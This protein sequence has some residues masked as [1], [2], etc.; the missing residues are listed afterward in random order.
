MNATIY[1]KRHENGGLDFYL[2]NNGRQYYLYTT[3][4]FSIRV[5]KEYSGGKRIDYV[6]RGSRAYNSQNTRERLVRTLTYIEKEQRLSLLN[7]TGRA[8]SLL[9]HRD[10]TPSPITNTES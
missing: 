7:K 9:S 5:F 3:P 10:M 4:K 6:F 2:E 1:C 8:R